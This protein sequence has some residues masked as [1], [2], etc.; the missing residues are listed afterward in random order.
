MEAKAERE[1]LGQK[2]HR[3]DEI[4][5]TLKVKVKTLQSKL[6]FSEKKKA[7]L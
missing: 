3:L 2:N 6:D 7:E 5:E 1:L 4:V